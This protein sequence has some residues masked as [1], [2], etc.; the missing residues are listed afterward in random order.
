M[1]TNNEGMM[2]IDKYKETAENSVKRV[3]KTQRSDKM[4]LPRFPETLPS[5]RIILSRLLPII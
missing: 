1:V 3:T 2:K 4:T 5:V